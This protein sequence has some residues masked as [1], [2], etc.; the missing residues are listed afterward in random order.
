MWGMHKLELKGRLLRIWPLDP[1]FAELE[2]KG[3]LVLYN[4]CRPAAARYALP[5][6]S[7][8]SPVAVLVR[9]GAYHG[10]QEGGTSSG[11]RHQPAR[12]SQP[13]AV[14]IGTARHSAGAGEPL[15]V[16]SPPIS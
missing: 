6:S 5:S 13:R 2:L 7:R 1:F 16:S 12:S 14:Y 11:I 4:P 3:G 8:Q 15:I 9:G 10:R